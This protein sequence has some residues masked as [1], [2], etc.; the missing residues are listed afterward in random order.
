MNIK[1]IARRASS[2]QEP[3]TSRSL[4]ATRS[5][6]K[7][8]LSDLPGQVKTRSSASLHRVEDACCYKGSSLPL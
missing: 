6:L 4:D 3:S 2:F 7:V 8:S 1:N 5:S